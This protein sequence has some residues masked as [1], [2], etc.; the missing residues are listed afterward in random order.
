LLKNKLPEFAIYGVK[1]AGHPQDK[2]VLLLGVLTEEATTVLQS[3]LAALC[4]EE[5]SKRRKL[6]EKP[7]GPDSVQIYRTDQFININIIEII[8][9]D[10]VVALSKSVTWAGQSPDYD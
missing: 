7:L 9:G 4:T 10:E 8:S 5:A 6:A 2:S 1:Y 3:H